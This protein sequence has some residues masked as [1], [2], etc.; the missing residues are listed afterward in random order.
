MAPDIADSAGSEMSRHAGA[1]MGV[2][3]NTRELELEIRP[4]G[5][6]R[7]GGVLPKFR[8]PFP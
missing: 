1:V 6:A 7:C 8:S 4:R 3:L 5:W 2:T